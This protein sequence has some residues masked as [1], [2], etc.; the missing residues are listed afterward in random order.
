[1]FFGPRLKTIFASRWNALFWSAGILLTAYC[2]VPAADQ[3]R[4]QQEHK[5]EA[6]ASASDTADM[7]EQRREAFERQRRLDLAKR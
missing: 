1:M 3:A 5:M 7:V 6:K 4:Q 2:T